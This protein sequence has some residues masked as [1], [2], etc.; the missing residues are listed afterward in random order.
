MFESLPC[1]TPSEIE[2]LRD[3]LKVNGLK[4]PV[5]VDENGGIID[6]KLRATLCEKLDIPWRQTTKVEAGLTADQKAALRI[7]LN[8]LRRSTPPT[9]QQKRGFLEVILKAEPFLSNGAIAKLCGMDDSTVSKKRKKLEEAGEVE[10]VKAVTGLD[11]VIRQKPQRN[12]RPKP[13]TV[14]PS[15]SENETPTVVRLPERPDTTPQQSV[16]PVTTAEVQDDPATV[17]PVVV[18]PVGRLESPAINLKLVT[19]VSERNGGFE[20]IAQ[21]EAG[22]SYHLTCRRVEAVGRQSLL[23]KVG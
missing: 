18:T 7:K 2:A 17:E 10:P 13:S 14:T 5:I 21:D 22:N 1:H 6:G 19:V 12:E 15:S 11:N 4:V 8:I 3:D 16:A 23:S 9:A 20:W